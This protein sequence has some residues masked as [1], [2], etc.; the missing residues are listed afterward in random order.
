MHSCR[1][2]RTQHAAFGS[3]KVAVPKLAPIVS[4]CLAP[5]VHLRPHTLTLIAALASVSRGNACLLYLQTATRARA[6]VAGVVLHGR[7]AAAVS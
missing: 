6:A 2:H 5:G 1:V 4:V 7:V 3:R